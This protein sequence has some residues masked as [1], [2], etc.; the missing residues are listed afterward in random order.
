MSTLRWRDW[1][2]EVR[3]V[4]AD[5]RPAAARPPGPLAERVERTVRALMDDVAR[6]ASRFDATSDLSRVNAAAGRLVPVRPLTLELVEVALDAARRTDGACDPT[7]GAHVVAAGYDADI[8]T[9]R[10]RGAV[11]RPAPSAPSWRA[12]RVDRDLGR[13]GLATGLALDLGATAKAW[14]ADE[15]ASRVARELGCP[16]LVALGG[17]VA[18]AGGEHGWPVLVGE[19]ADDDPRHGQVVTLRR[20]GLAT[21]STT[22]RRWPVAGRVDGV[23]GVGG[24]V[25]E[26]H[27]VVDPGTG[28][29]TRGPW[30]TASVVAP[31]CVTAN[32]L[33]TA[34]LVWGTAALDRLAGHPARLVDGAGRIVTTAAWPTGPD[35][36][37]AA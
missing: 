20:G 16:A 29:P 12:V 4:V 35:E 26:A 14:T 21:S 11:H 37:V 36:G 5:D 6:S 32:A 17:D 3:V 15:A 22:G 23:G 34:A 9:V 7:V 2:C 27:H 33:S 10:A 1:S 30:R 19:A 13:L 28:E 25:G 24:V 31:T 18:V 8:D